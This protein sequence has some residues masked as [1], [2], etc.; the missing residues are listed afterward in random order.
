LLLP[1]ST[2][3]ADHTVSQIGLLIFARDLLEKKSRKALTRNRRHLF[4]AR[5]PTEA[6]IPN[7]T[8]LPTEKRVNTQ[9]CAK[10][11]DLLD[12]REVR[13]LGN[14]SRT[15]RLGLVLVPF[16]LTLQ[17]CDFLEN[18]LRDILEGLL[19]RCGNVDSEGNYP[20]LRVTTT[21][22]LRDQYCT[23]TSCSLQS[24]IYTH[25]FCGGR[26]TIILT[27]DAEYVV[28]GSEVAE[29][30][31]GRAFPAIRGRLTIMGNG[32]TIRAN[33]GPDTPFRLFYTYP[34]TE[35]TLDNVTL[36]DGLARRRVSPR[37]FDHHANYGGAIYN[38]GRLTLR[39][40]SLVNNRAQ[41][42]GG[43]I[44]NRGNLV[45]E[46]ST[47]RNSNS[48]ALYNEEGANATINATIF[49][50]NENLD[51]GGSGGAIWNFGTLD[52]N[53]SEFFDNRTSGHGGA[54]SSSS[55]MSISRSTIANNAASDGGGIHALVLAGATGARVAIIG[56]TLSSNTATSIGAAIIA[57]GAVTVDLRDVTIAANTATSPGGGAINISGGARWTIGNTL[58]VENPGGNC[59]IAEPVTTSSNNLS[60]DAS[61][62]A[63]APIAAGLTVE[64][65]AANGGP[66][67]THALPAGSPAIDAGTRCEATDQRG[68]P[69]P[70]DGNGDGVAACDVG[71][72]ER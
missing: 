62:G 5:S 18:L 7:R 44:Y 29:E 49:S 16:S 31:G 28:S 32:A 66:T 26:R 42:K 34:P 19:Q 39:N 65:L 11:G 6:S 1:T 21:E 20:P 40:V 35:F 50:N 8:S 33:P 13:M 71:A 47:I 10:I 52:V 67:Q 27:K 51:L 64:A 37:P 22:D 59:G 43:A 56:S 12:R 14:L 61:C 24:A 4:S 55:T 2:L 54:I 25:N 38:H 30:T 36:A 69:R 53:Q 63:A 57:T 60:S 58:F 70:R 48:S 45:T 72:F 68:E 23:A 9:R 46:G 17:G 41:T 15:L 3:P